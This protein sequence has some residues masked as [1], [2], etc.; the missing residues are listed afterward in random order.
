MVVFPPMVPLPP[1]IV[2]LPLTLTVLLALN[3]PLTSKVPLETV[4]APV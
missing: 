2:P 3:E 1:R 4:V